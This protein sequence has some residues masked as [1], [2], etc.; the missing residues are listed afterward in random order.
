[1]A[2]DLDDELDAEDFFIGMS[3]TDAYG[4][5]LNIMG[6]HP[7]EFFSMLGRIVSL[8]ATLEN[9]ILSFYQYL[10]GRSQ[11]EQSELSVS[12]HIAKSLKELQRL[13]ELELL[14]QG[15]VELAEQWLQ[16]AKAITRRRNDYVH[17]L[18]PAQGGGM[19]FG[20]RVLRMKGGVVESVELTQDDMRKDLNRLSPCLRS[21][22][23]TA[24]LGSQQAASTWAAKNRVRAILLRARS[25][26]AR[27]SGSFCL[28]ALLVQAV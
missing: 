9:K 26:R 17:S 6:R 1:M 23:W 22:A 3:S 19:L 4:V 13:K 18:W 14:P 10:V 27:I 15:E 21:T 20:W 28:D 25:G 12:Q 2:E 24:S 7:E 5:P 8:A 16:E 11:T